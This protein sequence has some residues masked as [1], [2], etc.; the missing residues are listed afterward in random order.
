MFIY[1]LLSFIKFTQ[2]LL[3]H[4]NMYL[5]S[6]YI[7]WSCGHRTI[8]IY[9]VVTQCYTSQLLC[10]KVTHLNGAFWNYAI[11]QFVLQKIISQL[12]CTKIKIQSTYAICLFQSL[13]YSPFLFTLSHLNFWCINLKIS[14]ILNTKILRFLYRRGVALF[15]YFTFFRKPHHL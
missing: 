11:N 14:L 9:A 10:L 6:V 7:S 12:V 15:N 4:E 8:K 3:N 2:Y 5:R 13:P 1:A